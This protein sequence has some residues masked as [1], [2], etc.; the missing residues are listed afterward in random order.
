MNED[1]IWLVAVTAGRWQRKGIREAQAVGLKVFAID[2]DPNAEGF[3]DA[4]KFLNVELSDHE[5]I[6][7][8]LRTTNINIKGVVSFASDA[9]MVLAALIR[10]EFNLNGP[11]M[12]LTHRLIDKRIQREIWTK[13]GVCSPKWLAFNTVEDAMREISSFG[14]PLI[15]KPTD[16]SGSRGVT[17]I[18]SVHDNVLAAVTCAFEFSKSGN[19]LIEEFMD[20]TEFTV[21]IFVNKG[22][23]HI[24]AVTEKKKV[25]GTRGTVARELATSER[26]QEIIKGIVDAVVAGFKALGYTDGPGHAEVI[27]KN[28]GS[29]GLV[30]VAGRG[31]GFM[32]FDEFVPQVSGVNIARFTALQAVGIPLDAI[33][34]LKKSAVL[35]FFPST[36]GVVRSISGFDEANLIHG[37]QAASFVQVGHRQ[38]RALTDGDR[39]GYILS[40]SN[41]PQE[42]QR[43]ADKAEKLIKF[44]IEEFA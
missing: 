25:D 10:E 35:R 11:N 34:I 1:E 16:S 27:L 44:H 32:V 30:E 21:E 15:I 29:C 2:A 6:I 4:D 24:L 43:L 38:H 39:L 41:T 13:K 18:E 7:F 17:K 40:C 28:D 26:P 31:G 19:I 5:N 14:F 23:I 33:N 37:V 36:P 3:F 22:D 8:A 9:G 12:D 20:G 42:A